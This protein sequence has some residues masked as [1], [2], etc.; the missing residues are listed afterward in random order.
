MASRALV[1]EGSSRGL[2]PVSLQIDGIA[3]LN[4]QRNLNALSEKERSLHRSAICFSPKIW[5]PWQQEIRSLFRRP[6]SSH[7]PEIPRVDL[8]PDDLYDFDS[9]S[10]WEVYIGLISQPDFFLRRPG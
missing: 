10:G 8:L 4:A 2:T 1:G 3:E 5:P 9:F 7:L 6:L